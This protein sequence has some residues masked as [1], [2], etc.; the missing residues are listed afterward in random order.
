M[1]GGVPSP[2]KKMPLLA[3]NV[4]HVE[5]VVDANTNELV[6]NVVK[7]L[8]QSLEVMDLSN[9]HSSGVALVNPTM[10]EEDSNPQLLRPAMSIQEEEEEEGL[11]FRLQP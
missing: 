11:Q 1:F 7:N 5:S 3:E 6:S 10:H 4:S 9:I 2:N 8:L